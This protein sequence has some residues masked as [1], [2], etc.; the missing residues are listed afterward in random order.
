MDGFT[1]LDVQRAKNDIMNFYN[2]C[3]EAHDYVF[4]ALDELGDVL[5]KK[6]ASPI[7]QEFVR[8][9]NSEYTN[10]II[11]YYDTYE[12]ILSGANDAARALAK[13]N[14]IDFNADMEILSYIIPGRKSETDDFQRPFTCSSDINGAVGMDVEG[15]RLALDTFK[16]YHKG[17]PEL[18]DN[19]PEGIAFYD[20]NGEMIGSY[21]RIVKGFKEKFLTLFDE[22]ESD[23]TGYLE[24]ETDNILLAKEQATQAM[25][26]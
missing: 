20:P 2:S 24:T 23:L 11:E 3:H 18:F 14:G 25:N 21:N 13:S 17:L 4:R 16:T 26:G 12:H 7:A 8:K 15:V 5:H 19:I 9:Y 1:G 22:I 6:W 10:I